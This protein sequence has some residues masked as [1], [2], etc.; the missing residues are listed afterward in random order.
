MQAVTTARMKQID[1]AAIHTL[2]IPSLELMEHAAAHAAD[3]VQQLAAGFPNCR[4]TL[5]CGTGNN[6]GDGLACA[7]ILAGRGAA[8][9]VYLV[10]DP[11]KF[12]PDARVNAQRL[13]DMGIPVVPFS[14]GALPE[15]DCIVDALFGFGLNREV[16]GLYRKAIN[17][18][19]RSAAPVVACD[20]PSG[21]NG[22]TGAVMGAAVRADRTVTFTCPKIGLLQPAAAAFTGQL[23]VADIGIPE[24]LLCDPE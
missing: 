18:V 14:G 23:T 20:I 9:T 1:E 2:G 15:C 4:I 16:T 5:V 7:R 19:N 21:L 17:A 10:G 3:A 6:G 12:T 8:V 24:A 11:E 13:A 22:D